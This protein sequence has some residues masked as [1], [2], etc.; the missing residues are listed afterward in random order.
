MGSF[1][2][3]VTG[4]SRVFLIDGRARPDHKPAY[5]SS[6][7]AGALSQDFGDITKI[8]IPSASE[9]GKFEEVG[10]IRG[11]VDRVTITFTGRYA[12]DLKSALLDAARRQCA[13]DTHIN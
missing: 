3:A 7:K 1:N 11:A 8:E 4:N 10:I 12:L 6:L 5:Q 9:Y 13:L 2:P